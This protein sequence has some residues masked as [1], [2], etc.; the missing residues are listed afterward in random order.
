MGGENG[1]HTVSPNP[2]HQG[3]KV[4][5]GGL[6]FEQV[7][8][9]LLEIDDDNDGIIS[10][11][12]VSSLYEWGKNG[13]FYDEDAL[14]LFRAGLDTATLAEIKSR[15]P[16]QQFSLNYIENTMKPFLIR[17]YKSYHVN[18]ATD[19]VVQ[20]ATR[21][22]TPDMLENFIKKVSTTYDTLQ[23]DAIKKIL[24]EKTILID[25]N[26]NTHIDAEDRTYVSHAKGG[27]TSSPIGK[28]NADQINEMVGLLRGANLLKSRPHFPTNDNA[29]PW[30]RHGK[31]DGPQEEWMGGKTNGPWKMVKIPHEFAEFTLDL[32]QMSASQALDAI[33]NEPKNYSFDCAM[34]KQVI[35]YLRVRELFGKVKFNELAMKHGM[36]I[37]HSGGAYRSGLLADMTSTVDNPP[38]KP[39][40]YKVG[41]QGYLKLESVGTSEVAIKELENLQNVG[42]GGEHFTIGLDK[43]KNKMI[44][45]HPFGIISAENF[46]PAF[47]SRVMDAA[48][49][50]TINKEDIKITYTI[51]L[52]TSIDNVH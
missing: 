26:R 40:G 51:P 21:E 45:A 31:D 20:Q 47:K 25:Y 52:E 49:K 33:V 18:K 3:L 30:A 2:Y 41:W 46:E 28:E 27:Y 48:K 29:P 36:T 22:W 13:G 38:E 7:E 4:K 32:N 6:S 35:Q 8:K 5:V 37:G 14:M 17:S 42:W 24:G 39:E 10:S 15:E 19:L 1:V 16:G 9:K 43:E 34:A 44:Y 11:K 23:S 50:N 12:N